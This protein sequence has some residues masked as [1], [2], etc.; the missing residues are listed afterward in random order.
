MKYRKLTPAAKK[1]MQKTHTEALTNCPYKCT[2]D[3][4]TVVHSTATQSHSGNLY[5]Y[6]PDICHS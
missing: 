4:A 3:G 5:S 6:P 1:N 2:H